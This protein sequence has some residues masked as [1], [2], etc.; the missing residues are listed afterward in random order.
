MGSKAYWFG[1]HL[2]VCDNYKKKQQNKK[3]A[4]QKP[5]AP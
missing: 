5:M 1:D 4:E 2:G 3:E